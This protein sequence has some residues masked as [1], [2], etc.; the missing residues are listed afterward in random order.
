MSHILALSVLVRPI[1]RQLSTRTWSARLH[2][3]ASFIQSDKYSRRTQAASSHLFCK[4]EIPQ[5]Q[6]AYM[7]YSSS[8]DMKND[9]HPDKNDAPNDYHLIYK[10]PAIRFCRFVS[11]LKILQTALTVVLLPPIYYSYL[12][13]QV[14]LVSVVYCTGIAAFAGGMLYSLSYYL[15]R[16]IGMIYINQEATTLKVAH[17]T[18]W[19]GRKDIYLPIEDVKKLSETGD[20]KRE[21][22]LQLQTY[23]SPHVLYFTLRFAQ[24]LDKEKF[25]QIF[26][27]L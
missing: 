8:P 21:I 15:R 2:S 5:V 19:G 1:S 25:R 9:A 24:I 17:L 20:S 3:R 18:F 7:F 10:F 27:E 12:Q 23:S 6:S 14:T 22:I 11:R 13:E 4:Y 16:F 26:G